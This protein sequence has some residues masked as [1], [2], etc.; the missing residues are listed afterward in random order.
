MGGHF[1]VQALDS[2]NIMKCKYNKPIEKKHPLYNALVNQNTPFGSK[3][4]RHY[5]LACRK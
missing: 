1:F 5:L 2:V 3:K 4:N